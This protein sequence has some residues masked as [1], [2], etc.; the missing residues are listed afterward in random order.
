MAETEI[1]AFNALIRLLEAASTEAA[2]AA[3]D[4]AANVYLEA[5][6][7]AAPI[8]TSLKSSHPPGQLRESI[9]VIKSNK[10]SLFSSLQGNVTQRVFVGPEKKTGYYGYF[11]EKGH[12]TAG[13]RR[14][15]RRATQTG[16]SQRG[17]TKSNSIAAR[18]WFE[19]AI[20]SA[21]SRA[22]E[23]G[24]NAFNQKL[25]EIDSRR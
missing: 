2:A 19:R 23:A 17:S 6:R 14:I 11:V 4:A 21:E 7:S 8:G 20:Q 15:A 12:K 25:E 18:P 9:R 10:S 24:Q 16:H 5:A 13:R 22:I 3:I 1:G